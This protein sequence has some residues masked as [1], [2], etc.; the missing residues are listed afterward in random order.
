MAKQGKIMKF[1]IYCRKDKR[2]ET[3][4][5]YD[6]AI[7]H[8]KSKRRPYYGAKAVDSSCRNHGGCPWCEGNRMYRTNR[9]KEAAEEQF[10]E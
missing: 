8:G 3:A 2:Q 6:K 7:L 1:L 9:L 5:G 4:M 10:R